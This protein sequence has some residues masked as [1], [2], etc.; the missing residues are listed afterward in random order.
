MISIR[1]GRTGRTTSRRIGNG[2]A[3]EPF[4]DDKELKRLIT[5]DDPSPLR[6]AADKLRREWY[7]TDVYVRGLIEFSNH[8]KNNCRY[9]GIRAG[10]PSVRRYRL[11]EEEIIALTS[12]GYGLGFR[13]FV[14]QSGED[15]AFDDESICRIIRGI[16]T[17]HPDCAV[18]LS[19]GEK[20]EESYRKYFEAGA[21][22]YLLRHET[23]DEAHYRRLHP[24]TMS[25]GNRKQCLRNLKKIGFQV[26]AGFMVGSPYQ[27]LDNL[28]AD[29]RFLQELQPDMI[30]IGPFIPAKGTPFE[31]EP[32]GSLQ[33]TLNLISILRIMFP[34][35]LIPAT[36]ALGSVDPDGMILGLKA[37][38]N[39]LMP[40]L[41]PPDVRKL[42]S[43]YDNKSSIKEEA[44]VTDGSLAK[45]VRS[46]G[47]RIVIDR[48]DVKSHS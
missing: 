15:P 19:I 16:K 9:C 42:Y 13:T 5:L 14:L 1:I 23:A 8:C 44:T 30:G 20:L 41:T 33:M 22:R 4:S 48:G 39:V 38:A 35:A 40:N 27:T 18:T 2:P 12:N 3:M 34:Y 25:L 45:L 10:N 24:E 32:Q 28:V 21:S 7:G 36:T 46:A 29:L 31:N 43:I 6:A 11:A 17:S 37:G 47:Y 26:G